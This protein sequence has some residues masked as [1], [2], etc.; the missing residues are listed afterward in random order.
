MIDY[1]NSGD[2]RLNKKVECPLC[3]FVLLLVIG[4]LLWWLI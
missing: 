4:V 3:V 2:E 1:P